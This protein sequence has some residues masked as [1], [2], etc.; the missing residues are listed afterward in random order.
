MAHQNPVPQLVK[1]IEIDRPN[2]TREHGQFTGNLSIAPRVETPQFVDSFCAAVT[3]GEI[4][5][6]NLQDRELRREILRWFIKQAERAQVP[7]NGVRGHQ[8]TIMTQGIVGHLARDIDTVRRIP[9]YFRSI[10]AL[11]TQTQYNHE[12]N[13]LT[14]HM[15]HPCFQAL[16]QLFSASRQYAIHHQNPIARA[17][18]LV[19]LGHAVGTLLEQLVAH[20]GPGVVHQNALNNLQ[21]NV[22]NATNNVA[23]RDA[24]IVQ[25]RNNLATAQGNLAVANNTISTRDA[26]IDELRGELDDLRGELEESEETNEKIEHAKRILHQKNVEFYNT[27]KERQK[28]ITQLEAEL[29]SAN[30]QKKAQEDE[31]NRYRHDN[32]KL[33]DTV[34]QLKK[35]LEEARKSATDSLPR[36]KRSS[37]SATGVTPRDSGGNGSAVVP[38][39]QPA[40]K[41][42]ETPK[43]KLFNGPNNA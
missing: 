22:T 19:A 7:R 14:H 42:K 1:L 41:A 34:T 39:T 10:S 32:Q 13:G 28:T 4:N 11:L 23:D 36:K 16:Q 18:N 35:D 37:T 20:L 29:K 25:L 9:D 5:V 43:Q 27:A 31:A 2:L 17:N 6:A 26:T 3:N 21:T 8:V 33:T 15:G 30:S 38:R 24:T 12:I 40:R